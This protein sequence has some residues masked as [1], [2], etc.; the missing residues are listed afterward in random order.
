M[1]FQ[2]SFLDL[3][4]HLSIDRWW[5]INRSSFIGLE[6]KQINGRDNNEEDVRV[7]DGE[8]GKQ[9]LEYG[10]FLVR[11]GPPLARVPLKGNIAELFVI[12]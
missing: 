11:D 4:E 6:L 8:E 10:D 3:I 7:F 2:H 1:T 9:T 12:C 5:F